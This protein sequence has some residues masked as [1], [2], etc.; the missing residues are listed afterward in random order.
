[1]TNE[2]LQIAINALLCDLQKK[3]GLAEEV[4]V[5][6]LARLLNLQVER[7]ELSHLNLGGGES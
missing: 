1:M 3:E 4:M 7:A 6:A 2:Q 5:D